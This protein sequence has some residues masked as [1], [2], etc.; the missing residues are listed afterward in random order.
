MVL[1]NNPGG[2][3]LGGTLTVSFDVGHRHL[4]CDSTLNVV[5]DGYLLQVTSGTLVPATTSNIDVTPVNLTVATQ[6]PNSV[7]AGTGFGLVVDADTSGELDSSFD[8]TVTVSLVNPP[9]GATLGG[10]LSV[11]A[12]DGVATFSGLTLTWPRPATRSASPAAASPARPPTP[13]R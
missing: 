3:T 5:A 2:A 8:G 11:T 9:G 1:I 13:S 7:T 4:Q 12:S 6:P 10:T